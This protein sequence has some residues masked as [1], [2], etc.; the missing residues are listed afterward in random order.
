MDN[1]SFGSNVKVCVLVALLALGGCSGKEERIAKHLDRAQ[2]YFAGGD[3]EKARV[4]FK[5]VLQMDAKNIDALFGQAQ[6]HEKLE[7]WREAAG[8]YQQ[9]SDLDETRVDAKERLARLMFMGGAADE[10]SKLADEVLNV[11]ADSVVALTVKG[12]AL[13][14]KG[15]FDQAAAAVSKALSVA[16]ENLDAIMLQASLFSQKKEFD[17]ALA[18]LEEGLKSNAGDPGITMVMAQINADMGRED[19][20]VELLQ[21]LVAGQ[22]DNMTYRRQLVAYYAKL[23][24]I[25]LAEQTLREG[26]QQL[27]DQTEPK[28]ML[29]DFLLKTVGAEK[30]LQELQGFV[31]KE[32]SSAELQLALASL[33]EVAGKKD[34]ARNVL[35]ALVSEHGVDPDALKA[36]LHLARLA[37][38]D[39]NREET[40]RLVDEVLK[41]NPRDNDGLLFR[42]KLAL[43]QNDL[44]GAIGDLRAV[45]RDQPNSVEVLSLLGRAHLANK[46]AELAKEQ[47]EKA[48]AL[49]PS[50]VP[51]RFEIGQLYI[52]AGQTDDALQQFEIVS[53]EPSASA[54][55][56]EALFKAQIMKK[57]FSAARATAKRVLEIQPSQGLGD[58][59]AGQVDVAEGNHASAVK[60]FK[61]ALSKAPGAVEAL[62]ALVKSRLALKQEKEAMADV[63]AVLK[64]EPRHFVA[65]NILGEL[66]LAQKKPREAASAFRSA[67]KLNPAVATFYRNLAAAQL[68]LQDREGALKT[69]EEG[70]Q[71]ATHAESL[72]VD[73]AAL[74]ESAG[75]I[76]EA[77]RGYDAALEKE[78]KSVV[79]SN[80]LAMLLASHKKDPASLERAGKLIETLRGTENPA[81]LDTMGWVHY[82]RG[83]MDQALPLLQQAANAAPGQPLVQYHLGMAQYKKGDVASAKQNLQ[84]ALERKVN[85]NGRNEADAA[86]QKIAAGG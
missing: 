43:L 63:M 6:A 67:L 5:N 23:K 53:R 13:A 79:F 22:P 44:P 76:D 33:Y 50:P 35:T 2:T 26:V 28:L 47:F 48:V 27:P 45:L 39:S 56:F 31:S 70:L 40:K 54:V 38:G 9:V 72:V 7:K 10:A 25:D 58:F 32:G 18:V 21:Q 3:Y 51:L 8:L 80:N 73:L 61:T 64:A 83:E 52:Q 62:T 14:Q 74:H 11:K 86:L 65:Q 77:I 59:F 24:K 60:R 34:D 4:E 57:D 19:K 84:S 85:F 41:E 36:R 69:L 17:K 55:V 82:S 66:H 15:E 81:Y 37:A 71:A 1:D 16:P 68:Q 42:G 49:S 75:H 46:E 12:G 78:P 20:A 30:A 29:V